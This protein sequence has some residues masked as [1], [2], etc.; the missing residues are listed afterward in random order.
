MAT[1]AHMLS[2]VNPGVLNQF[3][4]TTLASLLQAINAGKEKDDRVSEWRGV[5]DT[6]IFFV[7][8]FVL[9][10]VLCKLTTSLA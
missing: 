10:N 9:V 8:V 2:S 7:F 3:I 4:Q 1:T 5:S 6:A